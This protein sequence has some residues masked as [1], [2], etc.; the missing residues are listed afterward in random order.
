MFWAFSHP[1][2][3]LSLTVSP[4]FITGYKALDYDPCDQRP[5]IYEVEGKLQTP[6]APS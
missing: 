3:D 5:I 1:Q 4:H 2:L 6:P